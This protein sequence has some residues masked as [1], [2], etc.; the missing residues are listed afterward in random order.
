LSLITAESV[1]VFA[2][3]VCKRDVVTD[4]DE[5]DRFDLCGLFEWDRVFVN[6]GVVCMRRTRNE[7]FTV[8]VLC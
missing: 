2:Y 5:M 4:Y 6:G 1:S 7:S 3:D 8:V